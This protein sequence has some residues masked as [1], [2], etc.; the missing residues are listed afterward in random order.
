MF[1]LGIYCILCFIDEGD[2][3]VEDVGDMNEN[4]M[5]GED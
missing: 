5:E 1:F 4:M 3:E 2:S